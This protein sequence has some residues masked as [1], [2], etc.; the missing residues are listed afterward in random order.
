M[1][2]NKSDV[3]LIL[4]EVEYPGYEFEIEESAGQLYLQAWY[5]EPDIVTKREAVQRTRKWLIERHQHTKSQIV[6]TAFKCVLTSMEHR[7]REH[8]KYRKKRIY[9][10]HFDVDALHQ[11]CT[12]KRFDV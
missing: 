7:A 5:L 6:Q 8:F 11:I 10:P 9:G 1:T 4:E 12:D 2:M 3:E